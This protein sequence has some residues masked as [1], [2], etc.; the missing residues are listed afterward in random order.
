MW[1]L[2]AHYRG[3]ALSV[4]QLLLVAER[5]RTQREDVS[6]YPII[7]LFLLIVIA[8][9]ISQTKTT[10]GVSFGVDLASSQSSLTSLVP[11]SMKAEE[12]EAV[13]NNGHPTTPPP[14]TLGQKAQ[15]SSQT[16]SFWP[17][18]AKQHESHVAPELVVK[19][20]TKNLFDSGLKAAA[21]RWLIEL[22]IKSQQPWRGGGGNIRLLQMERVPNNLVRI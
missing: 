5:C 8:T 6:T 12:E 15:C 22:L 16:A 1:L 18:P 11:L 10:R 7:I 17:S 14:A 2:C 20:V 21:G 9:P 19:K 4:V 3:P 13:Q